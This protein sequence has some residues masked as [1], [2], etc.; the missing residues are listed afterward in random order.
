MNDAMIH[1][2]HKRVVFFSNE[3]LTIC[4]PAKILLRAELELFN[5][6]KY[7]K[8]RTQAFFQHA[9]YSLSSGKSSFKKSKSTEPEL[10]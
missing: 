5:F 10:I 1:T 8:Y 9:I 2:R 7:Q 4:L 6:S 3:R